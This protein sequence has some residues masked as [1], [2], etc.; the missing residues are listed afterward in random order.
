[1]QLDYPQNVPVWSQVQ[2]CK[3]Q[4]CAQGLRGSND[5]LQGSLIST[6]R[7]QPLCSRMST[8]VGDGLLENSLSVRHNIRV[9]RKLVSTLVIKDRDGVGAIIGGV[10]CLTGGEKRRCR[11]SIYWIWIRRKISQRMYRSASMTHTDNSDPS[12]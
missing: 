3:I 7:S 9:G 6:V 12:F 8:K 2:H 4:G 1:M 10:S 5:S 11:P